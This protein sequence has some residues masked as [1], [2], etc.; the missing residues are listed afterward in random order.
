[1]LKVILIQ[2]ILEENAKKASQWFENHKDHQF[3]SHILEKEADFL[4]YLNKFNI[5]VYS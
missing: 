3:F 2:P 1:M 5:R 4:P